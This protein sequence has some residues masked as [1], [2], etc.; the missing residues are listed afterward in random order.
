MPRRVAPRNDNARKAV[1]ILQLLLFNGLVMCGEFIIKLKEN[2][3]KKLKINLNALETMLFIWSSLRDREKISDKVLIDLAK[4]PEMAAV[5]EED[6]DQDSVRK[7]LSAIS[8]RELMNKPTKKESRFWNYNMW[9]LEDAEM[10]DLMLAPV[11]T[12]NVDD[13][14][15]QFSDIAAEEVEIIFFPG[16]MTECRK[17]DNKLFIN[18]F[19]LQADIYGEGEVKIADKT[20]RE[21]IIE[22]LKTF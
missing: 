12:L 22:Q 6:F 21:Y 10:T 17:T 18:F 11:K 16:H 3:M 1:G 7:V 2:T 9:M 14:V 8:N 13:L 15:E 5:I 20:I 19:R 4:S